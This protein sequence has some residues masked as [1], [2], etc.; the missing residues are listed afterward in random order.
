ML[1]DALHHLPGDQELEM[2]GPIRSHA[3]GH[4]ISC[5]FSGGPVLEVA[6]LMGSLN[7]A[8]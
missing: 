2:D 8:H 6:G 5:H 4:G 3:A 1:H 7:V